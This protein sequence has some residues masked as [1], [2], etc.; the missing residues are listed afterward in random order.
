MTNTSFGIRASLLGAT[1]LAAASAYPAHA[2]DF[3]SEPIRI[4]IGFAAGGSTD[5]NTRALAN[6]AEQ[7]CDADIVISNQPGGSGVLALETV[8]NSEADG[9][10]MATTPTEISALKHL[11][12]SD[13][14]HEDFKAVMRFIFDPHGFFVRSGSDYKSMDDVIN[15]A[16]NGTKIR[17][18]TSGPASPYAVTFQD[19]ARAAG[20]SGQFVNIPYQ[21]DALAIPAALSGEVDLIVTNASNVVG[22]VKSGD[23]VP[24]GVATDERIDVMPDAPTLKEVGIEVTG[25][26]IYGLAAPKD[27]PEDRV[28]ALND[29]FKKAFDSESFQS[30]IAKTGVNP[31][32]LGAE[33]FDAYLTDEYTRY[34]ELLKTLGLAKN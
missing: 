32:Y 8:R 15:A 25:G 28:A 19:V 34:G 33:D 3:P 20:V 2:Q 6:A 5:T 10:T 11:G 21:G 18:A 26:S 12:L 16:K 29:C 4:V 30:F 27:T 31:A 7:V 17:I 9:Y 23:F 14:T 13:V 22:Q 1:M 24:L